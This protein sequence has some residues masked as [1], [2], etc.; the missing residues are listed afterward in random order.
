MSKS[1]QIAFGLPAKRVATISKKNRP[2]TKTHGSFWTARKREAPDESGHDGHFGKPAL[3]RRFPPPS[4]GGIGTCFANESSRLKNLNRP[5]SS[6]PHRQKDA[7]KLMYSRQ[8]SRLRPQST[9]IGSDDFGQTK[10][11]TPYPVWNCFSAIS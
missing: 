7:L 5:T 10:S 3:T 9:E 1:S 11:R 2:T 8:V 4:S 6:S